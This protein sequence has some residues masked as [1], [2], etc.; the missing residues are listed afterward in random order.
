M[1]NE[2]AKHS[3]HSAP[4]VGG[5][6]SFPSLPPEGHIVPWNMSI[7]GVTN[8][9]KRNEITLFVRY[10]RHCGATGE[11]EMAPK[12]TVL[13]KAGNAAIPGFSV[14]CGLAGVRSVGNYR[15]VYD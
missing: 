3:D 4:F 11:K 6:E 2:I 15:G 7:D 5:T 10:A 14:A 13:I 9:T 1:L 12:M 8:I